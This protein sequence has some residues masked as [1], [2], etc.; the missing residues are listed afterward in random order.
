MHHHE[1]QDD[2]A[3]QGGATSGEDSVELVEG[4]TSYKRHRRI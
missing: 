2:Q 1:R 3:G 4:D